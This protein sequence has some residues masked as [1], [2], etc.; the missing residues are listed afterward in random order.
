MPDAPTMTEPVAATLEL[1]SGV[2][3]RGSLTDAESGQWLMNNVRLMSGPV[4][5]GKLSLR[6]GDIAQL[7]T[8][9]NERNVERLVEIVTATENSIT[10]RE[11]P[12]TDEEDR[13][14]DAPIPLTGATAEYTAV[15]G[16]LHRESLAWLDALLQPFV[17]ELG[18]HLLDLSAA[19]KGKGA[20]QN[21][22]Y[23]AVVHLRRHS[24]ELIGQIV[25]QV[26]ELFRD[27]TPDTPEDAPWAEH[28]V[29]MEELDIVGLRE[30]ESSLAID[31]MMSHGEERYGRDMEAITIRLATLVGA[32]P[33]K[34]RNPLHLR[35][36]S[37][38]IQRVLSGNPFS[39][40]VTPA[41]MQFFAVDFLHSLGDYYQRVNQLLEQRGIH[42]EVEQQ[43]RS[44]GSLLKKRKVKNRQSRERKPERKKL[45]PQSPTLAEQAR[46]E[47]GKFDGIHIPAD[48]VPALEN[49]LASLDLTTGPG[50]MYRSV[51]DA[52]NFRREVEGLA[53]PG[54]GNVPLAGTWEGATID[55]ADADRQSLADARII[56]QALGSIQRDSRVRR[57]VEQSDSLRA[58][59]AEH[60]ENL[61]Q[62]RDTTGLTAE[63]LNQL[64]LVDN[65]FGT[66]KSQLDV[67][68]EL[69]PALGSLQI[70][71]AKLALLDPRFF[72]DRQHVARGVVDKLSQLATSANFPNKALENRI[73]AIV[74]DIVSDY[75]SDGSVFDSALAR[76]DRLSKQQEKARARNVERVVRTQEGQERLRKARERVNR[77][78]ADRLEGPSAPRVLLDLIDHGWRDLL[79][80]TLVKQGPNSD[81]WNEHL[82]TLGLLELWLKELQQGDVDEDE[83]MERG[84]E[85]G[86]LIDQ[87]DQEIAA[88]L[89]T[90]VS[91]QPVLDELREILAGDRDVEPAD[92]AA[93]LK[94]DEPSAAEIRAR[95][96]DLP[97]LRRWVNRVEQ[98]E[99][100][101]W[102]TYRGKDGQKQ[103]MRLAWI[104]DD[105][106]QYIFVN[107]RG[108]K[109]ADLSAVQ[110]ARQLSRGVQPPAP[111]DKLSVVDQSLYQ[112]LEHTQ[113]TL[114]FARN[115]D[116]LTR[117][118]NRETFL[119]QMQRALR[120]AQLKDTQ[121]AVLFINID[122]FNLVNDVYDRVTGDQVL[123]EFAKLLAQLHGKKASSARLEGD[124]FAV[125][126]LDRGVE[127][128][129]KSAD[130]IRGDIEAGSVE[131]DGEKVGFTV[132]IGVAPIMAHS[133]EVEKILDSARDA[134][135][136]AKEQGRNRVVAF[137][138]D[139]A[140]ASAHVAEKSRTRRDLE[141]ALSTDRFVLRA[142]PIMQTSVED[143][144]TVSLHYELLLGIRNKDGSLS[145]PQDFIISAEKYG[146]MNLVDRW[147]VKEA[148]SWISEL[149]DR[150]KVIPNLAINLSGTSVTDDSFME[151]LLEQ[152]SEFGVGTSRICFEITETGT[153]SNLVKAADFVRTFRNIGCKFS[154]DDFG[155][156]LASH[157][158]LRELPV[159]YVKIDGTFVKGIHQN[160][161]DYAMA[162]SINDL[163]HFLGQE[164]IAES[165]ENDA[166]I[167]KLR[168]I[169][170]DYLQG[171]GIA[172]PKLLVEVAQDLASIDK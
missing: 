125:L 132:S 152:I 31:R 118:I 66:I 39:D 64:D 52:L 62:L 168:E 20:E 121:H 38:C 156:G 13:P 107:E 69:K 15:L 67:T 137:R 65:L 44:T 172:K 166:I 108:Q 154:I 96:E 148:F 114:S 6:T 102:L 77:I 87:V 95:I 145:S 1:E 56:A 23:D 76:L 109:V 16:E 10:L 37:R 9:R 112:T 144:T 28:V 58:Y 127:Q 88:A 157:N 68:S 142:Q 33:L 81:T 162:R 75:E 147:V 89:P 123:L 101:A 91:H 3:L 120:H 78:I 36:L 51:V 50:T 55:A 103:R 99:K 133:P 146:F 53:P 70:P 59:L 11:A 141:E 80:L 160:R 131:I 79:V 48:K 106:N 45:E 85:A 90:Q 93:R 5:E 167:E 74:D 61:G 105:R 24:V 165:V 119:D 153:I 115:H 150:Q 25:R 143:G 126:L 83:M 98:L 32:E 72:L 169:S 40:E 113:K 164:T 47:Q 97:R 34:L 139:Q 171:W 8:R 17:K 41:I 151:Y 63:S 30:F 4:R 155:T 60:R 42:P 129:V 19:G 138:E 26:D 71:L 117:L 134:M 2:C 149:M 21:T 140:R 135:A 12:K 22:Y 94:T 163:A 27:L 14:S 159:D 29:S 7:T 92:V 49:L 111:A 130:K 136:T 46:A 100:D 122:Q 18:N 35:Q 86:P 84:L 128:A 82:N 54:A 57:D 170:V 43:I 124:E 161:N 158:Y 104:S 116:S 110:L 73:N